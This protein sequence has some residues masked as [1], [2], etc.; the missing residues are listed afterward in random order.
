M[1]DIARFHAADAAAAML[2][3]F[4]IFAMPR[5][6]RYAYD[7]AAALIFAAPLFYAT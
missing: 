4:I 5:D 2:L 1:R 7:A 3:R 6:C